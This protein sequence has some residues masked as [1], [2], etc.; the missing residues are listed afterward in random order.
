MTIRIAYIA[1][2]PAFMLA[3][4]FAN[5]Y[6]IL[7]VLFSRVFRSNAQYAFFVM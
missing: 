5:L 4:T 2:P 1:W 3:Y 6:G 7:T